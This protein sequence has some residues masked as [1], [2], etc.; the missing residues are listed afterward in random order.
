M[1]ANVD[2]FPW[3]YV[4]IKIHKT[5]WATIPNISCT[6]SLMYPIGVCNDSKFQQVTAGIPYY[7]KD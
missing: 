1:Q 4:I 7:F 6:G 3:F 2:P 5:L